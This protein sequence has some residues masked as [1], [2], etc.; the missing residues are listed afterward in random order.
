[1]AVS[2]ADNRGLFVTEV[3]DVVVGAVAGLLVLVRTVS[4]TTHRRVSGTTAQVVSGWR[5]AAL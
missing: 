3:A 1:L 5:G 4:V 2:R